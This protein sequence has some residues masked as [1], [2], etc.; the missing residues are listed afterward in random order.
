MGDP[1]IEVTF[2]SPDLFGGWIAAYPDVGAMT[3]KNDDPDGDGQSNLMEYAFDGDPASG[4]ANPKIRTR[5]E[6][7][8]GGMALVLTIPVLDSADAFAGSPLMSRTIAG[9]RY[10]VEGSNGLGTFDQGV[11]EVTPARTDG[12]DLP[13]FGWSYH[14]F[15][16]DGPIGGATPRGTKGFLRVRVEVASAAP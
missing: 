10:T 5:V 14:S 4:V 3:A 9:V 15:R 2:F 13:Y 1:T 8:N 6:D 16:L 11:S 12:M 7:V